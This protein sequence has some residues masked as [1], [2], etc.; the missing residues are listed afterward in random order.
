MLRIQDKGKCR[1][2]KKEYIEGDQLRFDKGV[3]SDIT[4][5]RIYRRGINL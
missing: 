4:F 5:P 2:P 1:L 3:V